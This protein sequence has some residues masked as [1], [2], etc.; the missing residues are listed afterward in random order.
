VRE[1]ALKMERKVQGLNAAREFQKF[2][3]SYDPVVE[4]PNTNDACRVAPKLWGLEHD[5]S[6]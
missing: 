6:P 3:K 5:I 2:Y 1:A 4:T